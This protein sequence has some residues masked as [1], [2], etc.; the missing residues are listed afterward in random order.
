MRP[1]A[2][3]R[4]SRSSAIGIGRPLG[5]ANRDTPVPSQ[6]KASP[7]RRAWR[8]KHRPPH[9]TIRPP[10]C[11]RRS[12][13]AEGDADRSSA[14][15]QNGLLRSSRNCSATALGA[16]PRACRKVNCYWRSKA[17]SSARRERPRRTKPSRRPRARGERANGAP[18]AVPCRPSCRASRPSSTSRTRPARLQGRAAPDREDVSERLEAS[19][20][21]AHHSGFKGVLQV[22]G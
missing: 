5:F 20:P 13:D 12:R 8:G 7:D 6:N 22:D 9:R 14:C 18:T 2:P 17:T 11:S 10:A 19:Q 4:R 3:S 16:A 21:I 1:I 15:V